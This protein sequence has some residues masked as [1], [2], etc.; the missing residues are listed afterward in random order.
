LLFDVVDSLRADLSSEDNV[1]DTTHVLMSETI[2]CKRFFMMDK[3]F[4]KI[5][6][7]IFK[8]EIMVLE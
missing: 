3:Y 1:P 7:D 6:K 5:P 8:V 4:S 2:G